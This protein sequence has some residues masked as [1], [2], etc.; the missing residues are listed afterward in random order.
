M[1]QLSFVFDMLTVYLVIEYNFHVGKQLN[2]FLFSWYNFLKLNY[3]YGMQALIGENEL[4]I[5]RA[6]E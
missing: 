4:I 2:R 1:Y 6:E 5:S 3:W